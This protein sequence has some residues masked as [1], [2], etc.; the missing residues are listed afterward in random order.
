MVNLKSTSLQ[1]FDDHQSKLL[2]LMFQSH[3]L[4]L[5]QLP[6]SNNEIHGTGLTFSGYFLDQL[7]QP[8]HYGV[9]CRWIRMNIFVEPKYPCA[10]WVCIY[11]SSAPC[12]VH[13][14][15]QGARA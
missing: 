2:T 3:K 14:Y 4:G 12:S 7:L 5:F 1:V 10:A 6:V 9:R 8:H 13:A 11:S 15:K